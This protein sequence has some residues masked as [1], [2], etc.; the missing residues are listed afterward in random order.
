MDREGE[1]ENG[2]RGRERDM[3]REG[4]RETWSSCFCMLAPG[5]KVLD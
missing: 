4:E 5:M 2:Q 1:R 3:D